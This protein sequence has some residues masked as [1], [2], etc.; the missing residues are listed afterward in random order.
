MYATST[1]RTE[2]R[3]S[4]FRGKTMTDRWDPPERADVRR[5]SNGTRHQTFNNNLGVG[6]RVRK[7]QRLLGPVKK[8]QHVHLAGVVSSGMPALG[9]Y[10][11]LQGRYKTMRPRETSRGEVFFYR[12][13][14]ELRDLGFAIMDD[15]D[16]AGT[17]R[18]YSFLLIVLPP[19]LF[20]S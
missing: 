4:R 6:R 9:S 12:K 3:G 18:T 19:V 14:G 1:P 8:C 17:H 16:Q 7:E 15:G 10:M 11:S 5:R 13:V 20:Q 2:T